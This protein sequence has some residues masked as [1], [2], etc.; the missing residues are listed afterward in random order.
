[1]P[2]PFVVPFLAF[3][4][5]YSTAFCNSANLTGKIIGETSRFQQ[6]P[7]SDLYRCASDCLSF[8]IC[9]AFDFGLSDR[10]C[11][12][13]MESTDE[14]SV[15]DNP[16]FIYGNIA[17]W[18]KTA[19]VCTNHVCSKFQQCRVR[20]NGRPSCDTRE[21]C[22]LLSRRHTQYCLD[23]VQGNVNSLVQAITVCSARGKQLAMLD[24]ESKSNLY[25]TYL[26]IHGDPTT[27]AYVHGTD[28][29]VEGKWVWG[30]GKLFEFADWKTGKPN[31]VGGIEHCL[32]ADADG[33]NDIGCNDP[34]GYTLCEI[35][36]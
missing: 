28:E 2:T 33:W 5:P 1:M 22:T 6:T 3:L 30:N 25:K 9:K 35:T 32:A 13:Y 21:I 20:R 36:Y 11:S 19:G 31:N 29:E 14:M 10:I 7:K 12:L 16:D 15:E 18:P 4:I 26:K 24:S 23:L 34:Y 27:S 17:L 8:S